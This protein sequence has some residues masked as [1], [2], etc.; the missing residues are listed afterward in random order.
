MNRGIGT[1]QAPALPLGYSAALNINLL[2]TILS[3]L[4]KV[5]YT[6]S[7]VKLHN[8]SELYLGID[9]S[10][11]PLRSCP[12]FVKYRHDRSAAAYTYLCNYELKIDLFCRVCTLV[13]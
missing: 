11:H 7:F 3:A 2:Y 6:N 10:L 8:N 1:L 12:F 13:L 4:S 5:S 9:K